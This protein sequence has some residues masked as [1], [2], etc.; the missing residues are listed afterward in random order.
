MKPSLRNTA[1]TVA[2]MAALGGGIFYSA[3]DKRATDQV[4]ATA[5][6][7]DKRQAQIV[8]INGLIA[9]DVEPY[10]KDVRV[11]KVLEDNNFRVTVTRVGSREMA[12]K[13]TKDTAPD[14]FMPSGVEIGRAHV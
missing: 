9:L 1:I 13:I 4:Q 5:A 3:T 12:S 7:A 8:N 11:I 14:F 6:I 2:L 10:F